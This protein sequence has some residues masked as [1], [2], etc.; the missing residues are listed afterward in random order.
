MTTENQILKFATEQWGEKDLAGI[1]LKVGEEAGEVAGAL[2]RIPEGRATFDDLEKEVGDLLIVLSQ[3]AA[4]RDTTLESLRWK[5]FEQIKARV[6]RPTAQ[7]LV[8]PDVCECK[9]PSSTSYGN[10]CGWCGKQR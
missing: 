2:V 3:I 6:P 9:G 8:K 10:T 5:R 7:R 1:G 4:K